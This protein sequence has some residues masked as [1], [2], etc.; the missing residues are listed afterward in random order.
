MLADDLT[1]LALRPRVEPLPRRAIA[2]AGLRAGVYFTYA[3]A[4]RI[5]AAP[6][7]R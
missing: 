3:S 7:R 1:A 2:G 5:A 4:A 6:L